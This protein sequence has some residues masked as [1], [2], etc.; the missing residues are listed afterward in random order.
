MM[1]WRRLTCAGLLALMGLVG[2]GGD[3]DNSR[4]EGDTEGAQ[5]SESTAD[6][7][8]EPAP[9]AT[10]PKPLSV[11]IEAGATLR[12]DRRL[13]VEGNTNLP[14]ETR[15][16]VMVEREVSGVR[17]QTRTGVTEGRF[18]AGPLG[19]GSGLPDGGYRITV[20]LSEASVQP[21]GVRE[22]IG[23]RG[24]ALE[25]PLVKASGHGLGQV[26]SYSRRFLIGNEPRRATDRVEVLEVD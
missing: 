6:I 21:A 25:G 10:P 16:V 12:S 15:L 14:D 3:D 2:C 1:A 18:T 23:D 20:N 9:D 26:A 17:W 24:E 5:Q 13:V 4:G 7:A 8:A 22:R 11:E 19:P